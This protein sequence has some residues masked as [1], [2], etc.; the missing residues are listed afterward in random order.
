MLTSMTLDHVE[1]YLRHPPGQR[2]GFWSFIGPVGR[3][4]KTRLIFEKLDEPISMSFNDETP[5][6]R[7]DWLRLVAY[8]AN[9]AESRTF[10]KWIPVTT[11]GIR[12]QSMMTPTHAS[13]APVTYGRRALLKMI[14]NLAEE[15]TDGNLRTPAPRVSDEVKLDADTIIAEMQELK[16]HTAL[17]AY[18]QANRPNYE[19]LFPPDR[20]R[21][22]VEYK[23]LMNKFAEQQT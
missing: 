9:G 14:F 10:T 22:D 6:D 19:K 4:E 13:I 3:D 16:D 20:K 21:I 15:D 12:G 8:V 18:G 11:T 23:A 1:Y 2:A 5:N 7:P 17:Y